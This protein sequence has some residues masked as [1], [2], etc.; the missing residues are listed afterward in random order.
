MG[1]GRS[2]LASAPSEDGDKIYVVGGCLTEKTSTA[3]VFDLKSRT[4][5]PIADT[6]AKRDSLGLANFDGGQIYAVGG[7]D[8]NLN[9][10]LN[11]VER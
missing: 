7:F 5:S 2:Y 9:A 8:N 1:E 6:L 11:S 10:Y 4:W 3:E